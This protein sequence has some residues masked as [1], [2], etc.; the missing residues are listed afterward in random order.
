M[1][2]WV[3]APGPLN[4]PPNR[5]SGVMRFENSRR[6]SLA[7]VSERSN[8]HSG[9]ET[10][11]QLAGSLKPRNRRSI[12]GQSASGAMGQLPLPTKFWV[13]LVVMLFRLATAGVKELHAP[14]TLNE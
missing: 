10:T 7:Q 11:L 14:D 6:K 2:C 5:Q 3:S 12:V 8:A 4:H 1:S 13:R 9:V